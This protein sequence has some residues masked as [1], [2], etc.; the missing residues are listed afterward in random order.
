[1]LSSARTLGLGLS[2]LFWATSIQGQRVGSLLLADLAVPGYGAFQAGHPVAAGLIAAGRLGTA[3]LAYEY[4]AQSLEM[5]SR[6]HAVRTAEWLYGPSTLFYDPHLGRPVSAHELQ[7]LSGRRRASS[8]AFLA[9]HLGLTAGSLIY[10][11]RWQRS[12][13][14]PIFELQPPTLPVPATIGPQKEERGMTL[15]LLIRL[16]A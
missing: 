2:C 1:M 4:H 9:L 7:I 15:G 8:Q 16:D 10:T 11:Y 6:A 13:F 5:A 14:M 3:F 12:R